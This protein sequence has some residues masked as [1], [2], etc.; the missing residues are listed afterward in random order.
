MRI[1]L[2]C[3]CGLALHRPGAVD[4]PQDAQ[5]RSSQR[6]YSC[7]ELRSRL[8][9]CDRRRRTHLLPALLIQAVVLSEPLIR[10]LNVATQPRACLFHME[11]TRSSCPPANQTYVCH[12]MHDA[13]TLPPRKGQGHKADTGFASPQLR[14]ADPVVDRGRP[15]Q[16]RRSGR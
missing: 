5:P 13:Q 11:M 12:A 6:K 8:R 16:G 9:P 7:E 10:G 2:P 4:H 15:A 1:Q 3:R 14:R